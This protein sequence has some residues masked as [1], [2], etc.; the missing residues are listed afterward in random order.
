MQTIFN[1]TL[2]FLQLNTDETEV[3]I[4]APDGIVPKVMESLFIH[5]VKPILHI[6]LARLWVLTSMSFVLNPV[7]TS[8]ET[9]LHSGPLCPE[10]RWR[11]LFMPLFSPILITVIPS[12]HVLERHYYTYK[13]SKM[14]LPSSSPSP[15]KGLHA[16]PILM[17]L[18]WNYCKH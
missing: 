3:L 6:L 16:I 10:L 11:W 13:W 14:L 9:L 4:F 7:S 12:S 8:W 2:N 17:S 18:H 1:Y 15:P 5:G